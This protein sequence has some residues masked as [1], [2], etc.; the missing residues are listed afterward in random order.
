[1]IKLVVYG[2]KRVLEIAKTFSLDPW[3]V[4]SVIV[5][6]FGCRRYAENGELWTFDFEITTQDEINQI[7]DKKVAI[8]D[9]YLAQNIRPY[10]LA[11][12]MALAYVGLPFVPMEDSG[13]FPEG[14]ANRTCFPTLGN[15]IDIWDH[16]LSFG[17]KAVVRDGGA[18]YSVD[19]KFWNLMDLRSM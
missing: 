7:P 8:P 4:K 14:L 12:R 1:M 2:E 17:Y 13:M 16:K 10:D 18:Y 6:H 5:E 9:F 19:Q 11:C 15:S 3:W